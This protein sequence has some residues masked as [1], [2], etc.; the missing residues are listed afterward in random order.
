MK[1]Y[2]VTRAFV[3]KGATWR[4]GQTLKMSDDE[5]SAPFVAEHVKPAGMDG[6]SGAP[7]PQPK[8]GSTH[9]AAGD[10]A[11]A[12]RAPVKPVRKARK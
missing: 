3:H 8:E 2:I 9:S 6:G 11:A 4:A 1:D 10:A 12:Y 7:E 5:A